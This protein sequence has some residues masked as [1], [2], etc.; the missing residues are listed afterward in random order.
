MLYNILFRVIEMKYFEYVKYLSLNINLLQ[1]GNQMHENAQECI[2]YDNV[3]CLLM[4][5]RV[6]VSEAELRR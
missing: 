6:W 2:L 4:A 1:Y 3:G 5:E